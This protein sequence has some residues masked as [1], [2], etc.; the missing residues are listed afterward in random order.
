[1]TVV[2][3]AEHDAEIRRVS[4]TNLGSHAREIEL[5]SYAEI[6]LAP[7]AADIAHPAFGN[8]FVADRV[9]SPS[10]GALLAT[11]RPRSNDERQVWAA[12]VLAVEDEAAGARRSTRPT[13]PASSAGAGRSGRPVSVLDGRPL[14]NTVGA[15]LDP[16]FS[17]RSACR[18]AAGETAHVIFSTVVAESRGDVLDLADKYREAATFERAATLAW[19]Q[20]QVQLRHLGI[21]G[22][23]A[24]LFQRLANRVLYADLTLRPAP[25]RAGA[26]ERGRP[27]LWAH[28]ISGDLPIVLV[29]ID[30]AEDIDIVRQLLRRARVL[31]AEA[32]GRRPRDRQ[33]ARGSRMRRTSRTRSRPWCGR[34]SPPGSRAVRRPGR[35]LILRGDHLS[36]DDRIAPA[37]GGAGSSC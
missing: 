2:V 1:M 31:A 20:A 15:V 35:R 13:G 5:T 4:L 16:I 26:N 29:R 6:V 28:G 3:S 17:L 23:E 8:L 21:E 24:H 37:G 12:H 27:G 32:P 33:R 9:R 30:Q 10:I 18:L 36:D 7:L 22:D 11:R 14:S 34:A 19:T 25:E